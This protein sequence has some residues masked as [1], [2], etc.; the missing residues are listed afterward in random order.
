[1]ADVSETRPIAYPRSETVR[2]LSILASALT[3]AAIAAQ[4]AA[5]IAQQMSKSKDERAG[6][7]GAVRVMILTTLA[8]TV[9]SLL[10]EVRTISRELRREREP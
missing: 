7:E 4:A 9:P 8:R 1:M 6:L 2:R 3:A 5:K 10:S